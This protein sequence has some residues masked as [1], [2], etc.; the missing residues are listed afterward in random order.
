MK[1][2]YWMFFLTTILFSNSSLAA[3]INIDFT[4]YIN[5]IS[6]TYP[7]SDIAIGD[8]VTGAVQFETEAALSSS[9]YSDSWLFETSD[10]T[11]LSISN[12]SSTWRYSS[13]GITV[14]INNDFFSNFNGYHYIDSIAI[15]N[16][17]GQG[18]HE[19]RLVNTVI[20]EGEAG[21]SP[22]PEGRSQIHIDLRSTTETFEPSDFLQSSA[23]PNSINDINTSAVN[24][25][26]TGSVM[27]YLYNGINRDDGYNFEFDID[28]STLSIFEG[29]TPSNEI[30]PPTNLELAYL[31]KDAYCSGACNLPGG[32]S[33]RQEILIPGS[34]LKLVITESDSGLTVVAI[35]GTTLSDGDASDI[36]ADGSWAHIDESYISENLKN[37]VEESAYIV[38][39]LADEIGIENIILTGHSLGGAIAQALGSASGIPTVTFNSP[40]ILY[41]LPNLQ[42]ELSPLIS[43]I[44]NPIPDIT[45]YRVEGDAVSGFGKLEDMGDLYTIDSH[46]PDN[47]L[48]VAAPV[49]V[50]QNHKIQTVIDQLNANA[51]VEEGFGELVPFT[52][53]EVPVKIE[54]SVSGVP[55]GPYN[56][57]DNYVYQTT[58]NS[59]DWVF[60]DPPSYD[61][62][63]VTIGQN[64]PLITA[65]LLPFYGNEWAWI[66]ELFNGS[67]W[68]QDAFLELGNIE[69]IFDNPVDS[70]RVFSYNTALDELSPP[71]GN[72]VVGLK[73]TNEGGFTGSITTLSSVPTPSSIALFGLGLVGLLFARRK[74]A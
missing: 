39:F 12:G 44:S 43:L 24:M 62:Y 47:F 58:A 55:S 19:A 2:F 16:N 46:I 23:L 54:P 36:Y 53:L 42:N 7:P 40:G 4:A 64:D 6:G 48:L 70:F 31:S 14:D 49:Y 68:Y 34:E 50:T 56:A 18:S 21:R 69:Y 29:G 41:K 72:F 71:P 27:M 17:F 73:F 66:M 26:G 13:P 20:V 65:A 57:I 3:L 45:N 60:L 59:T 30:S 28:M 10:S 37:I 22:V 51:G 67:E 15:N 35:Q 63:L 5:S 9:Y 61:G 1:P 38:A 25:S 32:F 11:K 52:K 74:K 33:N 8:A